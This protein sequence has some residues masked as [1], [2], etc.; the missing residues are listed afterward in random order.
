MKLNKQLFVSISTTWRLS[1]SFD[2]HYSTAVVALVNQ[3]LTLTNFFIYY[4]GY[5][6]RA[7]VHRCTIQVQE[8]FTDTLKDRYS[9][10]FEA[11]SSRLVDDV[12]NIYTETPGIQT[13]SILKF[14]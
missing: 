10:D 2:L 9:E 1:H 12:E 4:M 11:L 8:A 5:F 3:K 14:E 13:A 6:P 7:E